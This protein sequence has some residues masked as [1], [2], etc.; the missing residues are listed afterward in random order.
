LRNLLIISACIG[1][2]TCSSM[3]PLLTQVLTLGELR[4][5]TRN[6]PT[7]Y[8]LGIDGPT[9]PEYELARG[10]ADALGV[11]LVIYTPDSFDRT[12]DE[13]ASGRAHLAAAGI[14]L[15]ADGLDAVEA[16]PVYDHVT[17]QLIRRTGGP[18]AG[19]IEA[20]G[21][22]L[23][24]VRAG[25][26]NEEVLEALRR[27]HQALTW[28]SVREVDTD[29]LLSRLAEGEIDFAVVGSGDF[30]VARH[31][32]PELRVAFDLGEPRPVA[33]LLPR[34]AGDRSLREAVDGYFAALEAEGRLAAIFRRYLEP[35]E[36][37]D[38]VSTRAFVS[39]FETRLP[40]YRGHFVEAARETG[41]DWRLL[42]AVGYQ[43]SHWNPQAVSRTG[44]RG[45]MMLTQRTAQAL[46]IEDRVDPYQSIM[47][48]AR[49]LAMQHA[50][51]PERIPEPDRTW[52][53]LAAYNIG[54]GHLED[55][56]I[57]TEIHDANPD[58]WEDVRRHL[59]LLT[60]RQ[61]HSRVRRGYARGWQPVH[62]V[63]N[64]QRFYQILQWMTA[65]EEWTVPGEADSPEDPA[66]LA[67]PVHTETRQ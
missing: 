45:I 30:T 2:S 4:V 9:G 24:Q 61:W 31:V 11:S 1:L 64:V 46:D 8:Y 15:N 54:W 56:R 62:Y 19:G 67:G 17:P 18:A 3:P 63:D 21:D 65:G 50:R 66:T 7:S 53:A 44:V 28:E 32:Y 12:V 16:G 14:M 36:D 41:F 48:G 43:E 13:V 39:H 42:A 29:T 49:Y 60:Q 51:I 6:G 40:R 37:Y 47:G 10:L 34:R 33:W 25:S 27:D 52:L 35:L 5:V 55:A 22:R 58:S 57:L 59:P 26:G 23:L 20:L 38:Y